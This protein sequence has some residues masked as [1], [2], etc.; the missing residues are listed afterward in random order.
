MTDKSSEKSDIKKIAVLTSGGDSPGMNAATRAVVRSAIFKNLKVVGVMNGFSGLLKNDFI[1]MESHSVSKV[2]SRGGTMLKS[3]RCPEF[4][5]KEAR[6]R[7]VNNMRSNGIDGLVVLGGDG[8]FRGADLLWKEFNFPVVGAPCTID[9]DIYGTDFTIGFDTALNTAVTAI[10]KIRDTADS[11]NIL[12]FVEVMGRHSGF[13]ALHTAIATGAEATLIPET[14]TKINKLCNYLVSE[15]R[16]N[17]TSGI[18]IVAEGDDE[19]GAAEIAEKVK[20]QLPDYETRVTTLGHIQRGGS[21]TCN[22]RVLASLLGYECVNSLLE[23]RF[24]VMIGRVHQ[25]IVHVPLKE[26]YS[27]HD[28]IDKSWIK[29]SEIISI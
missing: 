14:P 25:K 3:S 11:H 23:K 29:I 5:Q 16:K 7:A 27:K 22:D 20:K 18:I 12:F 13:I 2:I 6:Q 9:N 24:G 19:G 15:R 8:S 28:E 21:P 10:D 1:E 4:H 17:K 26:A